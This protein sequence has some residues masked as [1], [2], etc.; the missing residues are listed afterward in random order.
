MFPVV[1]MLPALTLFLV[2]IAY[3]LVQSLAYSLFDASL[4]SGESAFVGLANIKA[5]L[6]SPGFWD[7]LRNTAVFVIVS[8]MGA[9]ILALALALAMNAGIV[10]AGAWRTGFL[11]PWILPGV[12][13][14]FLWSWIFNTNFGLLNGVIQLLG[15]KGDTN[16]LSSPTLAMTAVIVAKVWHSFPWMMVLLLAAMQAIP[17]ELHDAASVDGASGW[18]R[19]AYIV[20]P[21]IKPA[22]A[23]TLLLETIWGLQHFEIPWVMT[24]GGPV[25]STTLLSVG[26][27]KQAFQ[28]F[29]LGGAGAIGVLWAVIMAAVATVYILYSRR[30]ERSDA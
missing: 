18:K 11:L 1:L 16:W 17:A 24:G 8:T 30:Q 3:P 2:V 15:G 26:L 25:G 20:I 12:V 10:G 28:R 7:M 6:D 27:Y 13:V 14:S 21:Q 19:Q 5:L 4:L 29:D 22:M 9:F 23:L